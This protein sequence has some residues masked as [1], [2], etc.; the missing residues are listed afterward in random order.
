MTLRQFLFH[1]FAVALVLSASALAASLLLAPFIGTE[2]PIFFLAAV[3]ISGWYGGLRPALVATAAS[4][5][6]LDEFFELPVSNLQLSH[7]RTTLSL[8]VFLM[9]AVLLGSLNARLRSATNRAEAAVRA[10]DELLLTVSHDLRTPLTILKTSVS[11]LRDPA[12]RVAPGVSS[13]LLSTIDSAVDRMIRY[14]GEALALSR[15]EAGVSP[16]QEWNALDEIITAA[17]DRSRPALGERSAALHLPAS[18]PL[19]RFDAVLLEQS[20]GNLLDNVGQH[21]PAGSPFEIGA[22]LMGADLRLEVS[23]TGPGIP[24]DAR[25]RVFARYERLTNQGPGAGL[26]LAIA[27]AAVQAQGGKVWVEDSPAGGATFVIH[28]PHVLPAVKGA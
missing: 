23:D 24:P 1:P 11:T 8:V 19:M 25:E 17:L 21:T 20:L 3:A 26:G 6:V 22:H 18:L 2:V 4:G 10:R 27:R 7:P 13:Q 28:L 5:L 16:D 12:S 9:L 14:V 15:L